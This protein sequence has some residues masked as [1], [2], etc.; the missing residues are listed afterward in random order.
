MSSEIKE[1]KITMVHAIS[2]PFGQY[3][4]LY[5]KLTLENGDKIDIGKKT[6]QEKGWR[7][8]YYLD[9][10]PGQH[11]FCKAKSAMM[12]QEQNSAPTTGAQ[13]APTTPATT[14]QPQNARLN[15]DDSILFQ[16]CLKVSG[17]IHKNLSTT[18]PD[19]H[20]IIEYAKELAVMS[21]QQIQKM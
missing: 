6:K 11:E 14:P 10:D 13:N 8:T 1:S 7:V 2:D 12:P 16:V 18:M 3:Q 15:V 5:H 21:K 4:T 20:H 9:G 17:E 19:P